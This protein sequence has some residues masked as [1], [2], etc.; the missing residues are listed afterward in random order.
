MIQTDINLELVA[1]LAEIN[2]LL[3]QL[4]GFIS[5]FDKVLV[6]S[7]INV[8]SDTVGNLSMD[9]PGDMPKSEMNRISNKVGI[10]DRLI[11]NSGNTLNELFKKGLSLEE[12]I[13]RENP[14]YNSQMVEQIQR[15]KELNGLYKH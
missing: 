15:F 7:G 4:A 10:I 9:A 2:R 5:Q 14:S 3:P 6:E 8:M 1:I 12:S 11:N 13:K